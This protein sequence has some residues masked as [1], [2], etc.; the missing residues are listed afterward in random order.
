V[1]TPD[2]RYLDIEGVWTTQDF[3]ARTH[4]KASLCGWA[5]CADDE[6]MIHDV[7]R[8][9]AP[10]PER[11]AVLDASV[12]AARPLVPWLVALARRTTVPRGGLRLFIVAVG[13]V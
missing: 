7:E 2:G 5:L 10:T 6:R 8:I 1:R 13:M 12:A 4:E 9:E 11:A 3:L